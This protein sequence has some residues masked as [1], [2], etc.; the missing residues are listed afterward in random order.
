MSK[1]LND[2]E[3]FAVPKGA[4]I[5]L[6][7]ALMGAGLFGQIAPA[8]LIIAAAFGR[9]GFGQAISRQLAKFMG[10]AFST[11]NCPIQ[12]SRLHCATR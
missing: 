2:M 4:A 1:E 10:G 9:T 5:S 8:A 11:E 12:R 3:R 7:I 6:L